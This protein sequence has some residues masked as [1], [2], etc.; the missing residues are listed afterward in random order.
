MKVGR[1]Q[2]TNIGLQN[3]AQQSVSGKLLF[4]GIVIFGITVVAVT[5]I[6]II[7]LYIF[8]PHLAGSHMTEAVILKAEQTSENPSLI[9]SRQ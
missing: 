5:S 8:E 3:S 9:Q 7:P 2:A 6:W 4:W 1:K